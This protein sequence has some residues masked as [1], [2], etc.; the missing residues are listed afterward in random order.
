MSIYLSWQYISKYDDEYCRPTLVKSWSM[1]GIQIHAS[2]ECTV[3]GI[4]VVTLRGS[5]TLSASS[6]ATHLGSIPVHT[7]LMNTKFGPVTGLVRYTPQRRSWKS[8]WFSCSSHIHSIMFHSTW[9]QV[10]SADLI[11]H[12]T[13]LQICQQRAK[14][15]KERKAQFD[16]LGPWGSDT[17]PA[18]RSV[19]LRRVKTPGFLKYGLSSPTWPTSPWSTG[20]PLPRYKLPAPPQSNG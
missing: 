1:N 14:K 9:Q 6:Q 11:V 4:W 7:W 19:V 5:Q 15:K 8:A 3:G 17:T 20:T 10:I 18:R 13:H 16:P 12:I 2:K